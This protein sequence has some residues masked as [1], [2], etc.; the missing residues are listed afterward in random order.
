MFKNAWIENF[1]ED[2][3]SFNFKS[4]LLEKKNTIPDI[5]TKNTS[6]LPISKLPSIFE[7]K[8][9]FCK[10]PTKSKRGCIVKLN[11]TNCSFLNY[12]LKKLY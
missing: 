11:F 1:A 12:E 9:V 4:Q 10:F 5:L 3:F 6:K 2:Y 7:T 8:Y